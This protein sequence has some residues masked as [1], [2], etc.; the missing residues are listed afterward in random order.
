MMVRSRGPQWVCSAEVCMVIEEHIALSCY[1]FLCPLWWSWCIRLTVLAHLF[2]LCPFL[3]VYNPYSPSV[4]LIRPLNFALMTLCFT[5]RMRKLA[6]G[7]CSFVFKPSWRADLEDLHNFLG[8]RPKGKKKES[9]I[10][11]FSLQNWL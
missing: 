4:L 2:L 3:N 11:I 9:G 1:R 7:C 5:C 6:N 8:S 10:M